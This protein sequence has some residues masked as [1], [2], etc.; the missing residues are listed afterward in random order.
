MLPI[1]TATYPTSP[2][3]GRQHD[4]NIAKA[5]SAT[6]KPVADDVGDTLTAVASYT[7]GHGEEKTAMGPSANVVA[8]DTRNKAP[9]FEDQDAETDGTQN[10]STTRKVTENTEAV[11]ADDTLA[12][13]G[14][15][16]A[17]NVGGVITATDPDPNMEALIYTLGGANA[18]KFRVRSNGQIEVGAGTELDYETKDTYMVTVM[19]EDSFGES[20][21]IRVTITVTDMDEAP[22]IMRAPD[23]NVAPEFASATTS[24]T[25]AENTVAGEDIGN[26]VAANDANGDALTYALSGTDAASFDIDPDTGQLMTK[27]ALDFETKGSYTVMVTATDPRNLSATTTVTITVTNVDEGF[28]VSGPAAVD[29]AENGTGPVATYTATDPESAT[30]TWTMEGDDAALFDL[31]SGG[32]LTFKNSPDHEAAADDDTDNAYEVTVVASAGTNEDRLD[33]TITVTDVDET[34]PADFDPLAQYDADDSGALDKDEV[35]QAINEY[36]FGEGAD[37]I[38]K[39]DVIETINLY[40]FG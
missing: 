15:D 2:G 22:E 3:S 19:A 29:Y 16:V 10:E 28:E 40:L 21:S 5:T 34:Q 9:V 17:D 12:N 32:M 38:S 31:S 23:A 1:L 25:V 37:A 4:G 27:V 11:A 35:I 30:I 36:L 33:V 7:D 18:G 14:E 39:D 13:D 26:P 6:Y 8:L 20:A 24:R